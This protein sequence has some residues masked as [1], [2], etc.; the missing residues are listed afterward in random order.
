MIN[1]SKITFPLSQII[2]DAKL[3]LLH[4]RPLYRYENG[5]ATSERIGTTYEVVQLGGDFEK[6][7]V[8]IPDI[9]I[10]ITEE[11]I[12][13]SKTPLTVELTNAIGKLYVDGNHRIQVSVTA[14]AITVV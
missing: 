2:G 9:D 13:A 7:N 4:A 11:E 5:I 10:D 3:A 1:V 14:E 12:S 8:K 6:F